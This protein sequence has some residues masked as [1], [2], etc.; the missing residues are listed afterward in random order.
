MNTKPKSNPATAALI[1][2]YRNVMRSE[3]LMWRQCLRNSVNALLNSNN[4]SHA[5]KEHLAEARR[6]RDL[7]RWD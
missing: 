2:Y 7:S 5:A 1:E 6:Y 4:W 3:A